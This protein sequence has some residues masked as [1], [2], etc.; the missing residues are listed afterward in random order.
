MKAMV[1]IEFFIWLGAG[2]L[3][4]EKSII[5]NIPIPKIAGVTSV[6]K[7]YFNLYEKS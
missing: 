4:L 5:I 3:L 2:P 6:A 1:N 7:P